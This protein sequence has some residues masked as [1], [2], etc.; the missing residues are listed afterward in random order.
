MSW[1]AVENAYPQGFRVQG[2]GPQIRFPFWLDPSLNR[3]IP[4]GPFFA[5]TCPVG[6]PQL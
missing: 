2:L 5:M 3:R 4:K 6:V 1:A